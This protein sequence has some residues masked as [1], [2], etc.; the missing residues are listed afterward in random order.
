MKCPKCNSEMKYYKNYEVDEDG[1]FCREC[2][3]EKPLV[4]IVMPEEELTFFLSLGNSA[5]SQAPWVQLEL[6]F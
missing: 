4:T 6:P 2:G 5:P 3:L 1:Y